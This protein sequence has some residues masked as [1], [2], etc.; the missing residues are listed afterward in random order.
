[1]TQAGPADAADAAGSAPPVIRVEHGDPSPEEIGVLVAI[2]A[3][4]GG[5]AG[6][7]PERPASRWS[8]PTT[9]LGSTGPGRG[10]WRFSGMPR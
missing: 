9:R 5:A 10:N 4:S 3:A 2:L 1:M 8:A 7:A 6:A